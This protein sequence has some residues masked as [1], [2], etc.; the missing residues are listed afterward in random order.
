MP[1]TPEDQARE[2]IDRMLTQAGSKVDLGIDDS[3]VMR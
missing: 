2:V 3:K 1:R